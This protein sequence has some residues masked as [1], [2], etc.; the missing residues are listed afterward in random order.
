[1][2]PRN[3]KEDILESNIKPKNIRKVVVSIIPTS[4][5][6][7]TEN[8]YYPYFMIELSGEG[9]KTRKIFIDAVSGFEDEELAKAV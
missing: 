2:V 3:N 7:K 1:M 5:V 8:I 4:T 9:G 6:V